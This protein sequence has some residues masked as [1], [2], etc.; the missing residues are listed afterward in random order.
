MGFKIVHKFSFFDLAFMLC[1][2]FNT[3]RAS[4]NTVCWFSFIV[5]C[6]CSLMINSFPVFQHPWAIVNISGAKP[7]KDLIVCLGGF[8]MG[9][10]DVPTGRP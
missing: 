10:F 4:N 7:V 1:V 5:P 2:S 3:V 8:T 9:A 6:M